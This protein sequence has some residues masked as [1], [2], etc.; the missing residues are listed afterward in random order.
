MEQPNIL[1]IQVDQ[2]LAQALGCYGDPVCQAP[3]LDRLAAEGVVFE[4]AY[5]NFPL[6]AP[7]RFSMAS[8]LLPSRIGA[9]DNASE[10]PSSV[11]TYAHCLRALGYQTSLS[12][13]MHFVG[14]D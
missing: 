13:K 3:N 2:L 1:F 5:S 10:F 7:S 8:G 11:P 6:C 9:Y 12:G 4:T 14:A